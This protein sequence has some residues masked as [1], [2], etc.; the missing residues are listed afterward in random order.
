MRCARRLAAWG[1][2]KRGRKKQ[3]RKIKSTR[4]LRLSSLRDDVTQW[5]D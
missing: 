2:E 1:K 5:S 4:E 3:I